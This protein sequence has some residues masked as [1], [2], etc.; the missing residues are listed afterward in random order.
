[1]FLLEDCIDLKMSKRR[2]SL[3][4][5]SS[6]VVEWTGGGGSGTNSVAV[7]RGGKGGVVDL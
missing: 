1:M 4:D 7:Q 6:V 2:L 5:Q 3:T